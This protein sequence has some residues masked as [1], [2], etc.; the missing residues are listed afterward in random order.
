MDLKLDRNHARAGGSAKRVKGNDGLPVDYQ[1]GDYRVV[2]ISRGDPIGHYAMIR[3]ILDHA[4]KAYD[5]AAGVAEREENG[6][7]VYRRRLPGVGGDDDQDDDEAAQSS[8][9][10]EENSNVSVLLSA[11]STTACWYVL[12]NVKNCVPT[13][14][15]IQVRRRMSYQRPQ[16]KPR[17]S[18][19]R[20]SHRVIVYPFCNS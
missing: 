1:N 18:I 16:F 19:R 4:I 14:S 6:S 17:G 10:T 9:A 12:H 3:S 2:H 11:A 8:G 13:T 20:T 15:A 5:V 7:K